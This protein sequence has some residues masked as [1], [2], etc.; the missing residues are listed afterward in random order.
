MILPDPTFMEAVS[1]LAALARYKVTQTATLQSLFAADGTTL[2]GS[3]LVSN[4]G[5]T[6]TLN[7]WS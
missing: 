3:A 6:A 1:W 5:T 4:D 7:R 2:I